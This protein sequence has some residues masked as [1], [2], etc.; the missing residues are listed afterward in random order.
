MAAPDLDGNDGPRSAPLLSLR[1]RPASG[2]MALGLA[3]MALLLAMLVATVVGK[4][5]LSVADL[6]ASLL[7]RF[8]GQASPLAPAAEVVIWHVRLPRVL[9]GA[10]A[11]LALGA[12]GA[13]YQG[14]FRNP[15]VSPDILGVSAGSGLGAALAILLGLPLLAVSGLAF[16][17]GLLAVALVLLVA[18]RVG[19]Q[20]PV[21]V[22]VLAGV[23]VAALLGAGLSMVKLLADPSVQL[24]TITFWL[25]GGLNAAN[26]ADLRLAG[27]IVGVALLPLLLWRWRINLLS[28]PDDE[29]AALGLAVGTLR[30]GVVV[31][32]T[33]M[34]AAVV[35]MAGIIGWVGLVVPHVARLLV[36]PEFSR[37]LPMAMLLGAGFLVAADT[38]ARTLTPME[39]PLSVLT[40]VVGAPFFLWLLG[41]RRSHHD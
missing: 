38:L 7:A 15:L 20:D 18:R 16:V 39:L 6:L 14:M 13:A 2:A 24:P 10:L 4:F 11:G 30:L 37:L 34:T 12:A 41:R 9:A 8:G 31:A 32:A 29:A 3:A 19:E 5:P 40:A 27:P 28:L 33:L 23:A 17:G 1:Q 35:A 22:L 25:M 36:G 26:A 21:L